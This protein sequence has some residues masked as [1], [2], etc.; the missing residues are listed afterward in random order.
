[1][2]NTVHALIALAIALGAF[3]GISFIQGEMTIFVGVLSV[4][5]G[6]CYYIFRDFLFW[7][8]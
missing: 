7:W 1:M 2:S 3:F 5:L 8:I 6:V 4:T